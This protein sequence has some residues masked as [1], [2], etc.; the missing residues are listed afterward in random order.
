MYRS[1]RNGKERT[2]NEV[3]FNLH[4]CMTTDLSSTA[5]NP[6]SFL[7]EATSCLLRLA[8]LISVVLIAAKSTDVTP[9]CGLL[10]TPPILLE[11]VNTHTC[12]RKPDR[13]LILMHEI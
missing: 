3:I 7:V 4:T 10:G 1:V 8:P 12:I 6:Y 11:A 5:I 2:R 13:L 9:R